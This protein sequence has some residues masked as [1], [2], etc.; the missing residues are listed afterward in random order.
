[1]SVRSMQP[2][3]TSHGLFVACMSPTPV[4]ESKQ[5]I[6]CIQ[7]RP[8]MGRKEEINNT[9]KNKENNDES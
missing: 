2:F 7:E 9:C 3:K 1:M 8:Q 5:G 4:I 6:K